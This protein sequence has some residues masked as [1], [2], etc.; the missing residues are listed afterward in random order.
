MSC[1][2]RLWWS[3]LPSK[4]RPEARLPSILTTVVILVVRWFV[5]AKNS[6]TRKG[7]RLSNEIWTLRQQTFS[8]HL[9]N[10]R[11]QSIYTPPA[12]Q[13]LDTPQFDFP[14][15][16]GNLAFLRFDCYCYFKRD[17]VRQ[18]RELL[19]LHAWKNNH[20]HCSFS[21][22]NNLLPPMAPPWTGSW[23]IVTK[24]NTHVYFCTASNRGVEVFLRHATRVAVIGRKWQCWHVTLSR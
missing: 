14:K 21:I 18:S 10:I 15:Q 5:R 19:L 13:P 23:K 12:S 16:M 22:S 17:F 6:L 1:I 11:S 24:I 2:N 3:S 7:L 4:T 9:S 20:H 8:I